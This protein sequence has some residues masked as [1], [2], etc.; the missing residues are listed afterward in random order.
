[1]AYWLILSPA[2]AS[3]FSPALP[4]PLISD[5]TNVPN[6]VDTRKSGAEGQTQISYQLA[7]SWPV[8]IT[9][10]DLFG[11]KVK[12]WSFSAGEEGGREGYNHLIWDGCNENGQKV[13]KG[14]YIAQLQIDSPEA[15]VTAIRKIGVIH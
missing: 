7:G 14:G 9:L 10:Y 15:T 6:P 13:A 11:F 8:T 12:A 5:L 4:A 2:A 1:M 3:A